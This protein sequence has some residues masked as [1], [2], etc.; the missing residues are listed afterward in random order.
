MFPH[1]VISFFSP[2][3]LA[4]LK[5]NI[6]HQGLLS[7]LKSLF[8]AVRCFSRSFFQSHSPSHRVIALPH[9]WPKKT[10]RVQQTMKDGNSFI[11]FIFWIG[12][13]CLLMPFL[14]KI[15]LFIEKAGII[16]LIIS[17]LGVTR[18]FPNC[19]GFPVI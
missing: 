2:E 5:K 17:F 1:Q 8:S 11:F 14:A 18:D 10:T 19:R 16:G 15:P 9:A 13:E 7:N 12:T 4:D 3:S 6:L